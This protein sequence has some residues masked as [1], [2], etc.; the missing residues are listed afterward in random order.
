MKEK[1]RIG[2]KESLK[3]STIGIEM[4]LCVIIGAFIGNWLD[5]KFDTEPK[6]TIL[7]FI[8]GIIAAGKAVWR[9]TKKLSKENKS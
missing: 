8:L 4:A 7:G 2:W 6:L 5:K 9:V 1:E 3:Y